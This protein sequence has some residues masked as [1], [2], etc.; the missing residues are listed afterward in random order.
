MVLVP[1]SIHNEK[2]DEEISSRTVY[3]DQ[4][5]L[6]LINCILFSLLVKLPDADNV[7]LFIS[8]TVGFRFCGL[9]SAQ[10]PASNA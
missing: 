9:A 3:L 1:N 10:K 8:F 7:R 2:A 5:R 6:K 4:N